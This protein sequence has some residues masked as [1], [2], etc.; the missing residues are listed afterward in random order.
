MSDRY[1]GKPFLRLLDSYI[2]DAIGH[3][4]ADQEAALTA[5]EPKFAETF[6]TTGRWRDV[7]ATQMKFPAGMAGAVRE[8]WDKGRPRFVAAHGREPDPA[9]FTRTFVDTNFPR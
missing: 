4:P 8:V 6:G 7:V 2:L 1:D 9:E 3:L 5:M